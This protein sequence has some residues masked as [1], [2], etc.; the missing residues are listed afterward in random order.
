MGLIYDLYGRKVPLLFFL[1]LSSVVVFCFPFL[2]DEVDFYYAII[3]VIP[4]HILA[5]NPFVP[6]LI[7]EESHGVANMLVGNCISLGI[8]A[9]SILMLFNAEEKEA[10]TSR[11]IYFGIAFLLLVTFVIVQVGM[12]DVI[13]EKQEVL[14]EGGDEG[15]KVTLHVVLK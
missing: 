13:K 7:E 6:D 4:L 9:I 3:F 2:E 15:N 1:L 5:S 12:K 10:F 8:V 11:N 14:V